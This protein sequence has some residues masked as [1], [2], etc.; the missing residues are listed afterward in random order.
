MAQGRDRKPSTKRGS[1][2]LGSAHEIV[3]IGLDPTPHQATLLTRATDARV[4]AWRWLWNARRDSF[5]KTGR[6]LGWKELSRQLSLEKN[7]PAKEWLR[8]APSP[9]LQQALLELRAAY[10]VR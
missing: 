7:R 4:W 1:G 3:E 10:R 8:A 5:R 2:R 6:S 9:A